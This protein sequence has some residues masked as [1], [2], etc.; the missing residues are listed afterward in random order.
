MR[1]GRIIAI[2]GGRAIRNRLDLSLVRQIAPNRLRNW[3]I[4]EGA[5]DSEARSAALDFF[6]EIEA[7]A[8]FDEYEAFCA[9][10]CALNDAGW[11]PRCGAEAEFA[12]SLAAVAMIGLRALQRAPHGLTRTRPSGKRGRGC[13]ASSK[14]PR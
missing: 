5:N 4:P 14:A 9:I 12:D 7:L 8:A 3:V 6:R 13:S 2:G 10:S 1:R 11:Q